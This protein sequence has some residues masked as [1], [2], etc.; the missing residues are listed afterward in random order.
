MDLRALMGSRKA[1]IG[2]GLAA[3][4]ILLAL[5]QR[6]KAGGDT[7]AASTISET[8]LGGDPN[9]AFEGPVTFADNGGYAAALGDSVVDTL[10]GFTSAL[11]GYQDAYDAQQELLA[12]QLASIS[13]QVAAIQTAPGQLAGVGQPAGGVQIVNA[14][15]ATS[16]PAVLSPSAASGLGQAAPAPT[17]SQ[18]QATANATA[19]ATAAAQA[20]AAQQASQNASRPPRPAGWNPSNSFFQ[21]SGSRAGQW[22]RVQQHSNGKSYRHYQNGDVVPV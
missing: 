19:N 21:T 6:R 1:Q 15:A 20:Q 9:P 2:A 8:A 7:A 16:T 12:E 13:G 11:Q 22:Y 17:A 18:Q 10:G 5:M 3:V 4:V 14:P